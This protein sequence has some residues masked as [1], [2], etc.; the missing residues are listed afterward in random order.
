MFLGLSWTEEG[1]CEDEARRSGAVKSMSTKREA[2]CGRRMAAS[3]AFASADAPRAHATRRQV[4]VIAVAPRGRAVASRRALAST[5]AAR[6]QGR[7]QVSSLAVG[8]TVALAAIHAFCS[9][10]A[11]RVQV[12]F[13]HVSL[14]IF[15]CM[16]RRN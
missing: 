6:A 14:F 16:M 12:G 1:K 13:C 7:C 8:A 4:S 2:H 11:A 3:H 9:A 15:D 5:E 10:D